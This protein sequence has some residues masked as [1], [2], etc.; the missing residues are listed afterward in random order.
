MIEFSNVSFKFGEKLIIDRLSE[1]IKTGEHVAF[2]GESGAGKSTLLNSIVGLA[3]PSEGEVSVNGLKVAPEHIQKIRTMIGWLPQEV[4]LPY[5]T[6]LE[7]FEELYKY[8][9]NRNKK[10]NRHAYEEAVQKLGLPTSILD[11][12][13]QKIS[14]GER[15]RMLII[16]ALLQGRK[17]LLMDEPTSA[18]DHINSQRLIQYLAQLHDTTVVTVTHDTQLAESMH[19]QIILHRV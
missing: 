7:M 15:Q 14:G 16:S 8:R 17:I 5:N 11:E 13:L 12:P 3:I 2:V 6:V 4:I 18:L 10:F 9:A 1:T 19:R